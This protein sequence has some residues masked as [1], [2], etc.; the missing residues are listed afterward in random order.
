MVKNFLTQ[1]KTEK[2]N[3]LDYL[4]KNLSIE[5]KMEKKTEKSINKQMRD[6]NQKAS[7]LIA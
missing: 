3:L 2:K 5:K 7:N 1:Q 4:M 6:I